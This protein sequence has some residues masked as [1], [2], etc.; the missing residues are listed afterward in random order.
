MSSR[1]FRQP[2]NNNTTRETAAGR[3]PPSSPASRSSNSTARTIV[4]EE[5]QQQQYERNTNLRELF[6][7][8]MSVDRNLGYH[9]AAGSE[10]RMTSSHRN[11]SQ[12][13]STH[14]LSVFQESW[15]SSIDEHHDGNHKGGTNCP[16]G[17]APF[18][19]L[20]GGRSVSMAAAPLSRNPHPSLSLMGRS[21]S[22]PVQQPPA[23]GNIPPGPSVDAHGV[24]SVIHDAARITDWNKVLHLCQSMP[25]AAAYKGRDGW[26]ALH[27]ACNR[28]CPRPDVVQ[29]LIQAYPE[30][31][32]QEE[33][34]SWLPLHYACR[35]KA[36]KEVVRLLL[37]MVPESGRVSIRTR[38]SKGRRPLYY[39]VRYDAPPGVAQL[40]IAVDPSA[41]LEEDQNEE[42]PLALVWDSWAEKLEGK[43]IVH[44]FLP[45]GS[46]EPEETTR[47]ERAALMRQRLLREPKL[48]KRWE[49]V[50][51]LLKAAFGFPMDG[52][53]DSDD[54]DIHED[55]AAQVASHK[56]Q[57]STSRSSSSSD[58]GD[59]AVEALVSDDDEDS[60]PAALP[61]QQHR[62]WRIVHA[63]AAVKCHTS[64]FLLACALHPEQAK[65]MDE[66]DLR[67]PDAKGVIRP[68]SP[69]SHQ[70]ALHLAASSNAGGEPGKTV[71]ISLLS[72]YREAAQVSDGVDGSLPLHL[73][74]E[75]PKKQDWP[76]HAEIL[77]RFYP[78]A[79][80]ISDFNGKLPLHRAAAGITHEPDRGEGG[81]PERSVIFQLVRA[82]PQA[83]SHVDAT[84]C[85]PFH[86]LAMNAKVWDDDADALLNSHRGAVQMRAGRAWDDRQPIHLAAASVKSSESL[87]QRLVQLH[88]RGCSMEDRTGKLPL[89][90]ACE[91]G[92]EWQH[93]RCIY[94]AFPAAL[95]RAEN[96]ER[97]WLPLHMA[98][99]C[100]T[101]TGALIAQLVQLY[102]EAADVPD[103]HGRYPLHLACSSGKRWQ[104]GLQVLFDASPV[105]IATGD[106]KGLLPLHI[107][108]LSY[109]R[110]DLPEET[111]T[112]S[113]P[114]VQEKKERVNQEE[115]AAELDIIF[116]LVRADPTTIRP[117][118]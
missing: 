10:R 104:G 67:R 51:M 29:A 18:Q 14:D 45:G 83:A 78:R 52:D 30:A 16:G 64:L 54:E 48:R 68:A 15:A 79:V 100:P 108:A 41:I 5:E 71:I 116:N 33:E 84:G 102:P 106:R 81:D 6:G 96:N 93:V 69:S 59:C 46:P 112:R 90:L 113:V 61:Q 37:H 97:G 91:L 42:S 92:K 21:V 4:S 12:S 8:H 110:K 60:K 89:H 115:E 2:N 9:F 26:T 111:T 22:T 109:C 24:S 76:L 34:K 70:T 86:Y 85:V 74:V 107:C 1:D 55:G 99:A 56:K 25:E 19:S 32:L 94:E 53:D 36:P 95:R 80:Q 11:L 44:S 38:D 57:E 66:S 3:I 77:Y 72:L 7:R 23:S 88:P 58:L 43:R 98:V 39:A 40:L 17:I 47:E 118:Y 13:S 101:A 103:R 49:Q 31:L 75:N 35:F 50:N 62:V 28:R 117:Y 82:F 63:T 20:T 27:H 114:K 87:L 73:C 105:A 65:E